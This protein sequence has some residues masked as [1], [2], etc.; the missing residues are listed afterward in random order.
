M[1]IE[2][3]PVSVIPYTALETST[4]KLFI[5]TRFWRNRLEIVQ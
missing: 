4:L 3:F 1:V 2:S 5:S